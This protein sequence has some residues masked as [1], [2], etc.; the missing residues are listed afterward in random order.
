MKYLTQINIGDEF[1]GAGHKLGE[2]TGIG[3]LVSLIIKIIF[4]VSGIGLLVFFILGGIGMIAGAGE[5]N[6]EKMEKSKKS[7]TSALIG[8][9]VVFVSYWIVQL[10]ELWT[11]ITIL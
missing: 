6:P 2:L 7:I 1:L 5:G 9:I 11:G 4:L 8:F 10:I 3:D